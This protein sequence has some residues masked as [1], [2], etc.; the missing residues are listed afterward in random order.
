M[1]SLLE[2]AICSDRIFLRND[3]FCHVESCIFHALMFHMNSPEGSGVVDPRCPQ[4][5]ARTT[6]LLQQ[7]CSTEIVSP[8]SFRDD[9]FSTGLVDIDQTGYV[10]GM[11]KSRIRTAKRQNRKLVQNQDNLFGLISDPGDLC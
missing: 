3:S 11:T 6:I 1:Y 9:I 10:S 2:Y 7:V 4:L 5:N 8:V